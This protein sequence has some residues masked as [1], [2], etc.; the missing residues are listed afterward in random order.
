MGTYNVNRNVTDAFYRYKMPRLLAKVEG[1]GNGIKTVIV[2]M[3]DIAKSLGRPPTYPTKFFGCELGAQTQFDI[4]ADRFIVNGAHE[5]V[6]LQ[7]MLDV[8]IKKFVLCPG[9]DN[10]ETVLTVYTKKQTISQSCK[11]CGYNGQLDMRHKLTTFILKNPPE[12]SPAAQGASLT[13]GK[14]A[15]RGKKQDGS[16]SSPKQGSDGSENELDATGNNDDDDDWAV[17]VSEAAVKARMEDLT[18]GAKGMTISD[19]LEKTPKERAD[20][21][22]SYVKQRHDQG[23]LT[24]PGVDKDVVL[25]AE[26]LEVKDKA[27]LVI[28]ELIFDSNILTQMKTFRPLLIRFTHGNVKAQKALL[29]ATELVVQIHKSVLLPKVPHILKGLYELDLIEEEVM[30]EWGSKPSRKYVSKELS[31]EILAKAQPF[32]KWLKEAEEESEDSDNSDVEIEYDDR[33]RPDTL[34]EQKKAAAVTIKT[35][36]K[37]NNDN[38]EEDFDIDAI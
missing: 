27:P 10:P 4:K 25:E 37:E 9:C 1:K 3:T 31:A 34:I 30:I 11:A 22:Y 28:C 2:N 12:V 8:F 16:S 21:F 36:A 7:Q 13:E 18:S 23:Q 35:V 33:A 24:K 6:K 32:I 29:G 38:E 20:L 5:A 17:D 19:D 26:R 14:R 15:K